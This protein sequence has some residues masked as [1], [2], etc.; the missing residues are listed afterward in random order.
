MFAQVVLKLTGPM[1]HL[2]LALMATLGGLLIG[3][4]SIGK[5]LGRFVVAP[6][7][8]ESST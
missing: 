1:D 4:H 5:R 6:Q 2:R 3:M 8:P 7:L